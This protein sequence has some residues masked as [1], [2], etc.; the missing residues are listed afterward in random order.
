MKRAF[1]V[2][3]AALAVMLV[4]PT[5][6]LSAKSAHITTDT[7]SPIIITT[8]NIPDGPA[9][10]GDD[11]DGD[12]DGIAGIRGGIPTRGPVGMASTGQTVRIVWWQYLLLQI[13]MG[14]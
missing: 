7:D 12:G 1:I 11:D 2:F 8:P 9:F 4:Y 5:S 10:S 3:I 6:M 14:I 13:R